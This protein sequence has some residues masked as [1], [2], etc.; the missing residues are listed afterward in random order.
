MRISKLII[1]IVILLLPVIVRG[2]SQLEVATSASGD[3][4][5]LNA[6]VGYIGETWKYLGPS[7][8]IP[9]E[10]NVTVVFATG[11]LKNCTL[12]LMNTTDQTSISSN[13][14]DQVVANTTLSDCGGSIGTVL[15]FNLSNDSINRGITLMS[16]R[17]YGILLSGIGTTGGTYFS[18]CS[19]TSPGCYANG[20]YWQG[21]T[22]PPGGTSGGVDLDISVYSEISYLD[23]PPSFVNM[24]CTS[25]SPPGGDVIP[26]Y[27]TYDTTPT[28]TFNSVINASCRISKNVSDSYTTMGGTRQCTG[29]EATTIHRC[30]LR[31]EDDLDVSGNVYISCV[32]SANVTRESSSGALAVDLTTDPLSVGIVNTT[33]ILDRTIQSIDIDYGAVNDSNLADDSIGTSNIINGAILGVDIA[34]DTELDVA[35]VNATNYDLKLEQINASCSGSGCTAKANCSYYRKVIIGYT[36][37]NS[38]SAAVS[39]MSSNGFCTTGPTSCSVTENDVQNNASVYIVCG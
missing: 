23:G 36:S 10:V 4:Q 33:H 2:A 34:N 12:F 27:M 25:C 20:M 38:L 30:T 28:F 24:N 21:T 39:P 26:P 18:I 9:T 14:S 6:N 7:G 11:T 13:M 19:Q 16:N 37:S 5:L 3:Q 31:A 17:E 29:G 22:M 15:R 32:S 8:R 35:M 1:L